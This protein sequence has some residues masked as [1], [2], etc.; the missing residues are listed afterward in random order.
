MTETNLWKMVERMEQLA[1]RMESIEE[2]LDTVSNTHEAYNNWIAV[3]TDS[4]VKLENEI[5]FLRHKK[6][7]L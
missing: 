1:D 3:A 2:Y 5:K 4:L 6:T 7:A